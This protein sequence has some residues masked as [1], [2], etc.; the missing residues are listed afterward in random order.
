MHTKVQGFLQR[1]R[2]NAFAFP[3][4]LGLFIPLLVAMAAVFLAA[5]V[6]ENARRAQDVVNVFVRV[7]QARQAP[8]SVAEPLDV[9]NPAFD[10]WKAALFLTEAVILK[11]LGYDMYGMTCHAHRFVLLFGE[12]VG[13]PPTTLQRCWNYVNDAFRLPMV[14][15][16]PPETIACVAVLCAAEDEKMPLPHSPAWH[17]LLCPHTDA[18]T[19]RGLANDLR[20]LYV[21]DKPAW[22]PSLRP[23]SSENKEFL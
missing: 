1:S 10:A 16:Y 21:G 8:D 18:A 23:G 15:M 17:A 5:K 4:I 11:E 14:V 22:L 9:S 19:L 3:L 7:K 6:E 12:L 2:T 13:C 20:G